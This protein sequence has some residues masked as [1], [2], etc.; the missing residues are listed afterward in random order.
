MGPD[1]GKDKIFARLRVAEPGPGYV[2]FSAPTE[3]GGDDEY[4]VQYEPE[5][6]TWWFVQGRKVRGYEQVRTRNEAIDLGVYNFAALHWLGAHLNDRLDKWVEKL[7]SDA[8]EQA[9]EQ[10]PEKSV[11]QRKRQQ[12]NWVTEWS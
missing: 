1:T 9:G 7:K 2:H 11:R 8:T 3:S 4:F 10:P 12:R 5:R 6:P